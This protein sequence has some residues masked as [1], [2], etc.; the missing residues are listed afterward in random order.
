MQGDPEILSSKQTEIAGIGKRIELHVAICPQP[1]IWA[2]RIHQNSVPQPIAAANS[3]HE[4]LLIGSHGGR[5]SMVWGSEKR[6]RF[7]TRL[8]RRKSV[9]PGETE[10]ALARRVGNGS[11]QASRKWV[12]PGESENS[13]AC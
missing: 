3:R 6:D 8:A 12:S 5:N 7:P 13:F 1:R 9:S 2:L 11:R 10:I 4:A